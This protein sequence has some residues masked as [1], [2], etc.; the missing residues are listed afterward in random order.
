[1]TAG[2]SLRDRLAASF[3]LALVSAYI[4]IA[5]CAIVVVGRALRASIDGRLT[6][7]AQA[8]T[9][10]AGDDRGEI[11]RQDRQQFA[12]VT[13]DAGGA[14][15]LDAAGD[16]VLGTTP[17]IPAWIPAT[18]RGAS[19]GRVFTSASEGRELRVIVERRRKHAV[20]NRIVVWQS[21]QIVHD[22]ETPL[23]LLLSGLGVLVLIGGY[24]AGAQIAK[25][26]LLPLTRITAI[27]AEIAANDLAQRVGPQ[28]HAD[29]LGLLAATFDRMLDRLQAAFERQ[30]QFTADASHD[31]RAPL[32]TLRAEVDLALRSERTNAQ[33]RSAL[34]E[35]ATDAD[36]LDHLIDTLLAAARADS[37]DVELRPIDLAV[38]ATGAAA[39]IEPLARAKNV[40]IDADVA[41]D[42]QILGDADLL[43]RALLATLHNALKYTPASG[44]VR[45]S[46]TAR[47]GLA[48]LRIADEGPGFS[49]P[50]LQHAFDRFWRDDS[51][52]GRSGSGLGLAIA[53]GSVRRCGGDIAIENPSAGGAL[54]TMT[55]PL[56]APIHQTEGQIA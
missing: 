18:L 50:A 27:V 43:A 23:V 52:R 45:I 56:R 39:K 54:V 10:I 21:L 13:A 2:L 41:A 8:V 35:I 32:S 34:E 55:F 24:W 53:Q 36:H 37:G 15:V 30:R 11:D 40:D 16:V 48:R 3:A 31:L 22:V 12:A 46:V 29:E 26:G 47:A 44:C 20:N 51:A 28:P 19:I 7:V 17:S 33:Y 42:V 38:L 4:V 5:V 6:T 9:A 25:R 14:L 1:V 49:A